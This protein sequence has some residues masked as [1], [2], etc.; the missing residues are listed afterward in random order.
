MTYVIESAFLSA[1]REAGIAMTD[2]NAIPLEEVDSLLLAELFTHVED[3]V[4]HVVDIAAFDAV[5]SSL[6]DLL[7]MIR[8][9]RS[10]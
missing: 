5:E 1:V 6:G 7:R 3:A 10:A 4:G 2:I 8:S 9:V